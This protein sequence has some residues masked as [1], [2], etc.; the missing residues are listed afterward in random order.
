ML[1]LVEWKVYPAVRKLIGI[2]AKFG[3]LTGRSRLNHPPRPC[4]TNQTWDAL[5][6]TR[7]TAGWNKRLGPQ[8][9]QDREPVFV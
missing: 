8:D 3:F 1:T 6:E 4:C 7:V 9:V 2:L 5:F